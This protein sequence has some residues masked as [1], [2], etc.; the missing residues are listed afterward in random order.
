MKSIKRMNG[1]DVVN[2]PHRIESEAPP[3][4]MNDKYNRESS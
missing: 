4:G 3:K 2:T 1:R